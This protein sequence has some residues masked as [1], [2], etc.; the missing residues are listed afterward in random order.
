MAEADVGELQHVLLD[1]LRDV[2][3]SLGRSLRGVGQRLSA[4]VNLGQ[5]SLE[6]R[7]GPW[8]LAIVSCR[9]RRELGSL[10]GRMCRDFFLLS[11]QVRCGEERSLGQLGQGG[12]WS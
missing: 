6:R 3:H 2:L 4:P 10:R 9:G 7:G 12:D 11:R 5:S 8:S 1:D